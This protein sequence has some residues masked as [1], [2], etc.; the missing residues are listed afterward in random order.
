[1][2]Y[3][4]PFVP[5]PEVVVRRMLQLANVKR[6]EVVY[7]LGCGDGRIVIMA[8][9]EFGAEAA[10]I[11]I[12]KDL[13]EQTLR[14]VKDLG[15]DNRIHV[16]Y[17]NFF[18]ES[19]SEADVV[20]MYLLTS[21]NERIKPKL[22]R[23]LRPSTRVV[24]HDFEMPGWKPLIVEDLY[25]EWRS[26]KIY[27]YKIPGAEIPV[28]VEDLNERLRGLSLNDKYLE[29]LKLIDGNRSIEEISN[30]SQLTMRNVREIISD[31]T[32]QGLIRE[33]RVVK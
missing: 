3:D 8:A 14:R 6:N 24:S 27:L 29:I 1:M 26:H 22:E 16:I 4:V 21:V 15:L 32:K 25:E 10:C 33:I 11:E 18:E 5:T 2:P 23:E 28:P 30:K 20:T 12:R 31:L 13:Y 7:D 19:L 17:G 9:R